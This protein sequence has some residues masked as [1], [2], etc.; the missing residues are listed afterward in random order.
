MATVGFPVVGYLHKTLTVS[1]GKK[2]GQAN[3]E[4]SVT[5]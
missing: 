3:A 1:N 4:N 2:H 5:A